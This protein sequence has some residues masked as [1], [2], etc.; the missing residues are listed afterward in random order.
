MSRAPVLVHVE[1]VAAG[2]Y[3][4]VPG[5]DAAGAPVERVGFIGWPSDA[6]P[7]VAVPV[8]DVPGG[9]AV[10]V[11]VDPDDADGRPEL[12]PVPRELAAAARALSPVPG[13]LDRVT[14]VRA[15]VDDKGKRRRT[16]E[17]H[18]VAT[19]DQVTALVADPATEDVVLYARNWR[20]QP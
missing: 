17:T 20:G 2:M 13:E 1:D 3:L 5:V 10:V 19:L 12:L 6:G 15:V 18:Q 14:L 16:R 8:A 4:R 9:P 7:L 11:L